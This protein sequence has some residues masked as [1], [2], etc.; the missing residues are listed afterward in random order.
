MSP[1]SGS[2]PKPPPRAMLN[3]AICKFCGGS[4]DLLR[5]ACSRCPDRDVLQAGSDVED[6]VE[7]FRHKQ[8]GS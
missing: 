8:H 6:K 4:G 1:S 5:S 3:T 2:Q 7:G